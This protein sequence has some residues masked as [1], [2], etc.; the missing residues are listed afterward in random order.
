MTDLEPGQNTKPAAQQQEPW[1]PWWSWAVRGLG[2][3]IMAQQ[4]F[5]KDEDR[6]WLLLCAMGMMLGEI[7]LKAGLRFLLRNTGGQE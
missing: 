1:S 2:F 5:L 4:A 6:Q 7:G 3:V